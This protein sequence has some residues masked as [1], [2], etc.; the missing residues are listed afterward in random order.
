MNPRP[1]LWWLAFGC[2]LIVVAAV[3]IAAI[4]GRSDLVG[5]GSVFDAAPGPVAEHTADPVVPQGSE[6][7]VV[8]RVEA[9]TA[10]IAVAVAS[11]EAAD[12]ARMGPH[13][14]ADART[15]DPG[16]DSLPRHIGGHLDPDGEYRPAAAEEVSHIGEHMDPLADE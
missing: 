15:Y 4:G 11:D 5:E 1:P 2:F 8:S 12:A 6:D 7:D 16:G 3:C 10:D 9:A 13:M 14:D